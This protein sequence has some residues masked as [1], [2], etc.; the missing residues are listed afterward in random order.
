MESNATTNGDTVQDIFGD[1]EIQVVLTIKLG[2]PLNDVR[3]V[4]KQPHSLSLRSAEGH[5]VLLAKVNA[6][7]SAQEAISWPEKDMYLKPG[8]NMKQREFVKL[9]AESFDTQVVQAWRNSQRR[10]VALTDFRLLVFVYAVKI[11]NSIRRS[12]TARINEASIRIREHLAATSQPPLE[13][14]SLALRYFATQHAREP[15]GTQPTVPEHATYRQLSAVDEARRE[16]AHE[17]QAERRRLDRRF[18]TVKIMINDSEVNIAVSL[19]DLRGILGLPSCDL[20]RPHN[21]DIP[22]NIPA[23]NM[24]DEDHQ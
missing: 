24:K 11:Q 20:R 16:M 6:I 7:L 15:D 9:S 3:A 19:D 10:K 5:A 13:Q 14:N 12:T 23:N 18:R 2:E 22:M 4:H 1:E 21:A 8:T 17:Q